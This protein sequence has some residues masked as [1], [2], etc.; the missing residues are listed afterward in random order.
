MADP[1]RR[2]YLIQIER[3]GKSLTLNQISEVLEK[4]GVELD[5]G[6]GPIKVN[7]TL[8]RYVVR[9]WANKSARAKA[10]KIAGVQ[11]FSDLG[12]GSVANHS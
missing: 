8:P 6:Y 5:P 4:A 10:E 3:K 1:D 9:G 2:Q 12:V 7:P 11:F